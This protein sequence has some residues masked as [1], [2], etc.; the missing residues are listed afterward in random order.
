MGAAG[1]FS[2]L[3]KAE[4]VLTNSDLRNSRNKGK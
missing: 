4:S 2:K 3:D 1:M